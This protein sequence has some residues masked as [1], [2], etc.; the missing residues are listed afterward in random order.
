MP[1]A[2][3]QLLLLN[4]LLAKY[5]TPNRG[6]NPG[7]QHLGHPLRLIGRHFISKIPPREG[8]KPVVRRCVVCSKNKLRKETTY[9]CEPC[10]APF[11]VLGCFKT[12]H[13][14]KRF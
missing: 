1:L 10:N 9:Y 7:V 5:C 3:F 6:P 13:T 4:E 11:C 2:D 12:Y 14:K 8:N